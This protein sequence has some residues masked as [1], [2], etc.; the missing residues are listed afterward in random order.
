MTTENLIMH[1][2]YKGT[3]EASSAAYRQLILDLLDGEHTAFLRFD[4][5]EWAWRILDPVLRAWQKG[6]PEPYP[7]GSSGPPCQDR[8]L[9]NGHQ[10]RSFDGDPIPAHD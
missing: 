9:S 8:L 5:V 6:K 7:A 10:W 2:D 4:E 1:A 3:T